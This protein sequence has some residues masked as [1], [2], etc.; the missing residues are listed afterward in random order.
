M[1]VTGL[2]SLLYIALIIMTLVADVPSNMNVG[3]VFVVYGAP[4]GLGAL[5]IFILL[6][7]KARQKP[8][9]H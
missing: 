2:V 3:I 7:R 4:I 5:I 1:F 8:A 6:L 9:L